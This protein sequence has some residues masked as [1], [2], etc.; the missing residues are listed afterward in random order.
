M[1][2]K[3]YDIVVAGAG[4]N[5]LIVAGYLAKAGLKVCVVERQDMVGGGAITRELTLPG[6]K[7][8]PASLIQMTIQANPL[9]HRDEL[10]LMSK[11]GLKYLFP[12]PACAIVFPDQR[13]LVIWRDIAK[14]CKSIEQFS[15]RD[16]EM[17]PKFCEAAGQILKAGNVATFSPV[18]PFGRLVSFMDS[19]DEGRE[20]LRTILSSTWDLAKEWFE[21]EQMR[22]A[23]ARFASEV[24]IGPREEG[25]GAYM[26][27]FPHFHK[28]GVAVP[29]GGSGALSEALAQCLRDMGGT[30]MLSSPIKAVRVEGG[31]AK[32]VVLENG[33]VIMAKKAVV[34]NLNVKQL[35]LEMVKPS[36]LPADFPS[37]VKRIRQ[38]TFAALNQAIAL[39]EPPKYKAG[40][41]VDACFFV[42][43]TPYTEDFLRTFD[44]FAYGIPSSRIP[45]LGVP[46]I[47][48]PSRAPKGKHTL[49]LYHYEPYDLRDG[50]AAAWDKIREKV[51]NDILDEV[52][53]YTT[54]M[55]PENILSKWIMS[56]LDLERIN[57]AMVGGDIMHIGAFVTQYFSNRPLAG[58]GRYKTPVKKLYMCGGSTHPGAG[59][60][61]GGRA[62]VQAIMEDL[63][64]DFKKVITK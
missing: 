6:F 19:S 37:K 9:I 33:D 10:G 39:N 52:R 17:Y 7:H 44:E 28:W 30:I 4:H 48:D 34:S 16:A 53:K 27:G 42:E 35:F 61:G 31:E 18:P 29:V 43:I 8:D 41:D 46:S 32:G 54:N 2:Q 12:D 49:Y 15:K 56:P 25:T 45:L 21:S 24:M 1:A 57:P 3:E 62:A 60:T 64:I 55:G 58:W 50:G 13:A 22:I 59:V 11:Y 38:S 5:G 23:L 20:Y 63:G 51:A 26:F 40:P 14:T 36:E 47:T